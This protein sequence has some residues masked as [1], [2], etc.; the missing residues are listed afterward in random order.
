[1]NAKEYL[2]QAFRLDQRIN[3]K[4]EQVASLKKMATKATACIQAGRVSGTSQRGSREKAL[5][6]MIDLEYEID[7][8]IDRLVDL[9][10]AMFNF[11]ANVNHGS[12][13]MLLELRYLE[14]KTWEEVAETMGY[15][16][17]WVYRLHSRALK[18]ADRELLNKSSKKPL[19]EAI[20]SHY[21][22]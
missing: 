20:K 15:E 16:L 17:R 4:L 10:R 22:A 1:M 13:R 3:S 19:K 8:D 11:V 5:V 21:Q 18:E 9:K 6:K 12:H 7:A 2:S 14:E